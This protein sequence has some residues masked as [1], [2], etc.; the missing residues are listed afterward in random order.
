MDIKD[1]YLNIPM[2]QYKYIQLQIAN[3]SGNV[4]KHYHLT[5]LPTPDGYVYC[6]IQKRLYSLPQ[7]RMIAQ[8]LPEKRL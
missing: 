1:F 6:K 3:M 4:I 7:A 5:D 8:Q 2:A